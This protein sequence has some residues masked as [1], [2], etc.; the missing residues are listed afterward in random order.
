LDA[1]YTE[2]ES[3]TTLSPFL[4]SALPAP[5]TTTL[6][7]PGVTTS[8]GAPGP[9]TGPTAPPPT[10]TPATTTTG[11]TPV[12]PTVNTLQFGR[13]RATVLFVSPSAS[14]Q[15]TPSTIA[16]AGY[17]FTRGT[18]EGGVTNT[19]HHVPLAVSHQFTSLDS[20]RLSYALDIFESPDS[21]TVT[22]HALTLGWTRRLT[23]TTVLSLEA[24][25]RFSEDGVTPDINARLDQQFKLAELLGTASLGY[26]R[27]ENFVLGQPGTSKTET[28]S[29]GLSI[30][31]IRSLLINV[32]PAITRL[33][34]GTGPDSTTYGVI[35]GASYQVLK[36]L[37]ARASYSFAYQSQSGGDVRRN[38]VSVSLEATYPYRIGE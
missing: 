24:G 35:V 27:S 28:F 19:S 30:E 38:V 15:L 8:P 4:A 34:S 22:T 20:G 17:A 7:A 31:P 33:T 36:W 1:N 29:G 10:G 3:V 23:P 32:N 11:P 25:P 26:S 37:S 12:N 16:S 13:Q 18:L 6:G 2:T 9:V 5:A 14:Y 21:D